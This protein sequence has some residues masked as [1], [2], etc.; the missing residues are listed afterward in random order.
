M[1]SYQL[2]AT[3]E[4]LELVETETPEP[5]GT[6]V[7]IRI[8]ASGVCHSDL[9]FW[10]GGYNMGGGK[11]ITIEE[12]GIKLPLTMGHEPVGEVVAL[13]A[14]AEG[15]EIGD[16]RLVF[17]W[18]GCGECPRCREGS[19]NDCVAMRTL[20]VLAPG[21]YADHLMVPHAKYLVDIAGIPEHYAC[22]LACAGVTSY[23]AL[24]KVHPL[25][26]DDKVVI[27]G[28]GG[29]GLTGVGIARTYLPDHE[30]IVVDID[31][32]KLAAARQA[33]ADHT[34][35]SKDEDALER[36][37]ELTGNGPGAI[38]DFVGSS[39]TT[40]LG[41]DAVRKGGRYI[42]VGLYGGEITIPTLTLPIRNMTLRGSYV[43]KLEEMH[44][45]IELVRGG[46]VTPIPVEKRPMSRVTETLH[47]LNEGRIL[48]RVVLVP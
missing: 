4:P 26:A 30:L 43:G 24:K 19:D 6:E 45:L 46:E 23:S 39:E 11:T 25:S 34:I 48:G 47:D 13:G 31:G 28:A 38:V 15:V 14:D 27:I 21:G 36:L 29:V 22:T 33:G 2:V 12:R 3:N 5:Q 7:L 42:S 1:K 18:I 8:T 41:Y 35:N 37:R 10:Q 32:E 44:E 40:K 20:G 9:Y 16:K 17:P